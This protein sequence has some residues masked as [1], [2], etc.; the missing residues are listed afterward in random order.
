MGKSI[1]Y[2]IIL[3]LLA[4]IETFAQSVQFFDDERGR[5]YYDRPYKRYE[6][7]PGKCITN[8]TMLNPTFVQTEIQSEASNQIAVQ[9]IAKGSYVQWTNNEAADGLTIRFSVPDNAEG[10]GTKCAIDLYVNEA[11]IRT[12]TLNSYWAWQYFLN[13]MSNVYP[14]NIPAKNKF[15]RMRFDEIHVKLENKIHAGITFKLVKADDNDSP[16]TIDF[17]EL[18][19]VPPPVSFESL[20]DANKVKYS[21]DKGKLNL[22]IESNGGKTIYLP[23]GIYETDSRITITGDN[24]KLIGAGMWYTEI[25]FN[26]P[27]NEINTYNC[28]GI[29]TQNSNVVLDG[30]FLN[31]VN[32]QRYYNANSRYQ[33]GKGLMSS[34]GSHS[35]IKNVWAEHFECGAWIDGCDNLTVS[36]CR[37]RNNYADGINLSFGSMN[38]VVEHCSFRNNGDDDI[39]TWSRSNRSCD[40]N[41]F[42][43]NTCENN[44]RASSLGFFGGRQNKAHHC[45]IIDPMEAG[46]RITCDFPGAPF[47]VEGCSEFHDISV[48]KGGVKSGSS[49]VNGDLWGNRQGALHI[50]SSSQYDLQNIKIYR[51]DLYDS[52]SDAIFIGSGVKFINNLSLNDIHINGT[53]GYGIYFRGAKGAGH[54]C[55]IENNRIGADTN[56]NTMPKEFSFVENCN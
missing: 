7:E 27:S 46:F 10:A 40:N 41:V 33:V 54:Y 53:Q 48:Y 8:G 35:V 49:G 56:T 52:K 28:R 14:D 47:S 11:F 42:R 43:Y 38:S 55:N 15:P 17:V 9:L 13:D 19:N 18:E 22:F 36:D 1:L 16:Y 6:A 39:A 23:A 30:L 5:G 50:N 2:V 12:I 34:F 51:I 44:W 20:P 26:A 4:V 3:S 25:Y 31:T 37:F 21:P 45:V 29:Q 32:N 24:T